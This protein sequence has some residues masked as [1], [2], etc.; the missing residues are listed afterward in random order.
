MLK[1]FSARDDENESLL[2]AIT[3]GKTC[4]DCDGVGMLYCP[5]IAFALQ[6]DDNARMCMS[7][8]TADKAFR[9]AH[10]PHHLKRV[11]VRVYAV[12]TFPCK[13]STYTRCPADS[14]DASVNSTSDGEGSCLI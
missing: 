9:S 4:V 13:D 5:F 12:R 14:S 8:E 1:F 11:C 3:E 10:S 2:G 7:Q 6:G